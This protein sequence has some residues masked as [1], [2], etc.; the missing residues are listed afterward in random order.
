MSHSHNF[1][2]WP[3][4]PRKP[5]SKKKRKKGRRRK[6]A[7]IRCGSCSGKPYRLGKKVCSLCQDGFIRIPYYE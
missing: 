3:A 7:M 6:V 2:W 1:D 5:A 4:E